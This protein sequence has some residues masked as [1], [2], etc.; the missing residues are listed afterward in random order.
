MHK[1]VIA[2]RAPRVGH[3]FTFEPA[4]QQ[5]CCILALQALLQHA[6]V[7][8]MG[9]AGHQ[10][11]GTGAGRIQLG[12]AVAGIAQTYHFTCRQQPC[13]AGLQFTRGDMRHRARRNRRQLG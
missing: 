4:R 3:D 5:R 12:H 8:R 9:I 13:Q 10:H 7:F 11:A 2:R 1:T 6:G